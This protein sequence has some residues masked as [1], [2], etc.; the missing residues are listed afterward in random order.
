MS[1]DLMEARNEASELPPRDSIAPLLMMY[2]P[3]I[4][5]LK[6]I[7]DPVST[8][9]PHHTLTVILFSSAPQLIRVPTMHQ[10]SCRT[11]LL[12]S[13]VFPSLLQPQSSSPSD[14]QLIFQY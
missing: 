10:F 1:L 5:A 9:L 4:K 6:A 7:H 3:L 8:H 14:H 2:K 11:P 12:L 13:L